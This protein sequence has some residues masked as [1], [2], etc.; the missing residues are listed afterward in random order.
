MATVSTATSPNLAFVPVVT[1]TVSGTVLERGTANVVIASVRETAAD[2]RAAT[3]AA[4]A[5]TDRLV[6]EA[7]QPWCLPSYDSMRSG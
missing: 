4:V 7:T 3:V 2:G 5:N 1:P 6:V